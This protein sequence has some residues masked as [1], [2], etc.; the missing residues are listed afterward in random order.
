[1]EAKEAQDAQIILADAA[2]GLADEAHAP[3]RQIGKSAH[4]VMDLAAPIERQ[5]VDGEVAPRRID[6]EAAPEAHHGM[7]AIGLDILAQRRD[8]EG[9]ALDH[10]GDGA[11]R[12]PGRNGL[13]ARD[14]GAVR[15]LFRQGGGG[16][17]DL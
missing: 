7:A 15:H 3:C 14:I 17:V 13:E 8:L 16:E 12:D 11:M 9:A 10:D 2:L 5:G 6:G 4:L 1:M